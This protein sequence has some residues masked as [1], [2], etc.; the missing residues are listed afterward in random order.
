SRGRLAALAGGNGPVEV[1]QAAWASLALAD[2][3]FDTVW[4]DTSKIPA[5]LTEVL[6][7]IPLLQD[8]DFRAK[9]YGRVL[10]LLSETPAGW[11][12]GGATSVKGRYVRI[13]LPQPGTLTLAEVQVFSDGKNIAPQGAAKQSST[14]SGG[15]AAKA[16]D[17][18]TDGVFNSGTQ[19]HTRENDRSPWW[20]VDLGGEQ[21]IESVVIWNRTEDGLGK[22]LEGYTLEVLD[23]NRREAFKKA[24]NPAPAESARIAVSSDPVGSARRAAIRAVVSMNHE[25]ATVFGALSSLIGKSDQ[26][27]EAARGIRALP[28]A[29]WP[30]AKA[31]E[32]AT[33]LV[34]WAKTV[35]AGDRTSQ[36]FVETVQLAGD[37]AGFL[38]A[39]KAAALRTDLKGLRVAVFVLRTVRE[40]MRYDAPRLVVEAGKPFELIVANDDFMPHNVVVVKPGAREAVGQAAATMLPDQLDSKGRAFIPN[41][42]EIL[43]ATRLIESGQR[44]TLKLTAPSEEGDCEYV[45]TFPGHYQVM[46]GRLVVTKDV[47]AYLQAHPEAPAVGA[48]GAAHKHGFE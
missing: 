2:G 28:A 14:S 17:G 21:P 34:A 6:N 20:E 9:A 16:I 25:P 26:V 48:T 15:T 13:S 7:G 31:G 29:S 47:D 44:E 27:T 36:D 37:L 41:R 46:W 5:Q 3:S 23:G 10:P 38:P 18:R 12:A 42:P 39:D 4:N 33:A 35:P 11:A 40:Q 19:T 1:R 30:K 22:R 43:G 45:C 8:P 32:T 24:G